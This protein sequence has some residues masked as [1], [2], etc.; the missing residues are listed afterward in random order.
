[1]LRTPQDKISCYCGS[2]LP[3]SKCHPITTY[4]AVLFSKSESIFDQGRKRLQVTPQY[5]AT[6]VLLRG[7][8]WGRSSRGKHQGS[9]LGECRV[10]WTAMVSRLCFPSSDIV[11]LVCTQAARRRDLVHLRMG[12]SMAII[13]SLVTSPSSSMTTLC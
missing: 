2:R 5:R 11:H 6:P 4:S 3:Q 7:N 10:L 12:M 8:E 13:M 9:L 1:M